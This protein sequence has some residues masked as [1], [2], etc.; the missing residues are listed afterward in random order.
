MSR[1]AN[2]LLT[3]TLIGLLALGASCARAEILEGYIVSISDGDTL[4][5][6]VGREQHRIRIAG[7]DA[8][9][10]FQPSGN[11][12]R[13]NLSRYAY[14]QDARAQCYK[15]DIYGRDVC[16]IWVEPPD[17]PGCGKSLDVGLAQV[18]QGMAW[19]DRYHVSEQS[20]EDRERYERAQT[21]AKLRHLGLWRDAKPVPP[22]RWRRRFP[23]GNDWRSA[24]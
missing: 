12:S 14:R 24:D 15:K 2:K 5:L 19:W 16:E 23:P 8:P 18:R 4:T 6:L 22:W 10:H 7:I 21:M 3:G 17:C 11:R 1:R 20:A 9:E 13:T